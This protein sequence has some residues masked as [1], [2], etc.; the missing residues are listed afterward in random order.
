MS[1]ETRDIEV[2][3]SKD[4]IEAHFEELLRRYK[5]LADDED[6]VSIN[7]NDIIEGLKADGKT[8]TS[9]IPLRYK[10]KREGVDVV[11]HW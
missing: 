10:S 11:K 3:I 2:S 5:Y 6:L 1:S 9:V 7:L 8:K 4:N